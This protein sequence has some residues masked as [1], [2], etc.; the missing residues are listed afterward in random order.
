M[1]INYYYVALA[2]YLVLGFILTRIVLKGTSLKLGF[3][4]VIVGPVVMPVLFMILI[5]FDISE[6]VWAKILI[7]L[8]FDPPEQMR[9]KPRAPGHTPDVDIDIPRKR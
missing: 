4:D 3:R 5:C 6:E 1:Q 8:H 7:I 9:A 2:T